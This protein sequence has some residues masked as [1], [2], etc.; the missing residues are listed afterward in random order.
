MTINTSFSQRAI[1]I[2][3]YQTALNKF[4]KHCLKTKDLNK[5]IY[6]FINILDFK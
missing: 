5:T 4:S 2:K 6:N 3:A 1:V